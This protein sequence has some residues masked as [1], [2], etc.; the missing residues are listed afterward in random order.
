MSKSN[1]INK[2]LEKAMTNKQ[3]GLTPWYEQVPDEVK[4]FVEGLKS[5]MR[6]G[7]KPNATAVSRILTEELNFP[8]SRT[9]VSHWIREYQNELIKEG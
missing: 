3:G 8:V 1:D 7:R 6:Q 2:L 5:I 4:P 9:R